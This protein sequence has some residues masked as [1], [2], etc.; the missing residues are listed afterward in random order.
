[1]KDIILTLN[2]TSAER[3]VFYCIVA[4]LALHIAFGGIIHILEVVK[5]KK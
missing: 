1:M 3:T 4:L 2:Q 5:K